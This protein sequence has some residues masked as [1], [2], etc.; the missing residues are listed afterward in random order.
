MNKLAI[1]II[2]PLSGFVI[3]SI[4]V[5]GFRV[6]ATNFGSAFYISPVVIGVVVIAMSIGY[7]L[8]GWSADRYPRL[9]L[10]GLFLLIAGITTILIPLYK[11][12]LN[13]W[14]FDTEVF[15]KPLY[16]AFSPDEKVNPWMWADVFLSAFIMFFMPS[17]MLACVLPFTI[18]LASSDIEHA[19]RTSGALIAISSLGSILGVFLTSL[20]LIN[21]WGIA[22]NLTILGIMLVALA[23]MAVLWDFLFQP[24]RST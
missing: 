1:Y 18:K 11:T 20:W 2:T 8:G 23:A 3:M 6:M 13:E 14:I 19:G 16:S 17:M 22:K 9:R 10:L 15:S 4:E 5:L 21:T 12:P 24:Q 7:Y